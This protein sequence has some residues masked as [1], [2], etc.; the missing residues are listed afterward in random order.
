MSA[1][2]SSSAEPEAKSSRPS[3]WSNLFHRR[4]E[5]A[6]AEPSDADSSTGNTASTTTLTQEELDRRVQAETDRR[7][8]K[9]QQAQRAE[10]RK[11]LR[12][13]D[14]WAYAEQ[15]RKEEEAQQGNFHLERL[16]TDLGAEHDK[17]TVDPVF[18]ALPKAEQERILKLDGAGAGLAGRKLV[19]SESLKALEKHW[20]AEGA[21]DA[22]TRLRRNPAFRKQVLSELRGQTP[23]PEMLPSGSA[24]EADKTV[25]SLLREYYRLG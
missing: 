18:F 6:E 7:E 2:E 14:P 12:D 15:E 20:K 22:E 17:V 10:E 25:S 23:E 1:S 24:S 21:K 4:G 11:R 19:V 16:V 8:A 5:S 9:R 13:S 3:W